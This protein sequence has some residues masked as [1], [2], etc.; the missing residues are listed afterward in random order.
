MFQGKCVFSGYM[1]PKGKGNTKV[2]NDGK[3]V[4]THTRKERTL[5]EKEVSQR[6]CK[7]T[8]SS[9]AFFKKLNKSA[10]ENNDFVQI[11]KIVR[12]FT[13]IP[14]SL[15]SE[16]KKPATNKK[17]EEDSRKNEKVNLRSNM[18]K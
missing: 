10:K 3:T 18:R 9:R 2:L 16:V 14:K 7:W 11:T 17:T 1:V 4:F 15:V 5:I 6:K 12:G 13:L 8:E